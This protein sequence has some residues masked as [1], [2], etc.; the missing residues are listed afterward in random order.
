L[1]SSIDHT[2]TLDETSMWK[3][4]VDLEQWTKWS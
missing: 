4:H 1:F 3:W 2:V